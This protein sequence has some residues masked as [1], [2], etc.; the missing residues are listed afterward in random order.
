MELVTSDITSL[1]WPLRSSTDF[2]EPP[3]HYHA[4]D[5]PSP[6][7]RPIRL[8]RR[9]ERIEGVIAL[10]PDQPPRRFKW[11]G[12]T[13]FVTRADGPER[14]TGEWWRRTSEAFLVRDYFRVEN[15]RGERFWV[16]RRGD[17]EHQ[18]TGDLSWWMH[19]VFG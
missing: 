7:P 14:I 9:P 1:P 11:R 8:L 3:A 5:W 15:E 18:Q 4:I 12:A 2:A 17:G 13:H 10:L 6:W 19:G 16:F